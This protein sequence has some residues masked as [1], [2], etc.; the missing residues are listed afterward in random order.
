MAHDDDIMKQKSEDIQDK[1]AQTVIDWLDDP[2]NSRGFPLVIGL[3][4]YIVPKGLE[5]MVIARVI[6]FLYQYLAYT[7]EE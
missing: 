2:D 1:Y 5:D 3:S 6:R 4:S 7:E